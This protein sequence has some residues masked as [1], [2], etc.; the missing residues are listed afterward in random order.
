MLGAPGQGAYAAAN[1]YL[2]ALAVV[3]QRQGLP[4]T[5]IAWGL[6]ERESLAAGHTDEAGIARTRRSGLGALTDEQGLALFDAALAGPQPILA[7]VRVERAAMRAQAVAGGLAAPF[8]GLVP[9]GA[10]MAGAGKGALARRL[11][12]APPPVRGRLVEDFVRTEVAAILGHSSAEEIG[13]TDAFKDLGFDSLAAVELR[14]RLNLATGL[15]L[16]PTVVFD[17]PDAAALAGKILAEV[18]GLAPARRAPVQVRSSEEPIAI[19]GMACRYPGGI[20]SPAGLWRLLEAGEESIAAMPGD[21][22]WDLDAIYAGD[23]E[24]PESA[25]E[26]VGGFLADAADFDPGFFGISPREAILIDPQQR[27]ALESSWEALEDAGIDP[28]GLRGSTAGVFAGVMHHDYGVAVNDESGTASGAASGRISYALGL[29]GPA[30]TVD[31]ACSSSLVAVHLAAGALRSGECSLALAGGSTVL[32]RPSVFTY[33]IRQQGLAQDGRCKSFSEGADGV[34]ISEGVGMLVLE[35]LSD[36][37]AN[38]HRVLATIRGS[39]V[40]QDGASN[41]LS[42]PNGPSQERVILQALAN[43]GLKPADVDLVEAH[44]TGTPLGDPIEAGAIL[45]TYG[46]ERE[47]PLRLGSLKSNIGHTQAAAGVGGVIKAVLAM[48]EGLMPKTLHLDRA[49]SNVDWERGKV[50]LLGEARE[51]EPN[52]HPRRAGV[53]SFGISGTNAHLILEEA[54]TVGRDPGPGA[55]AKDEEGEAVPLQG[56]LPFVLSAKGEG[57]LAAQARRLAAH[58]RENSGLEQADLAFSLI[59]TRAQLDRRGVVVA[60][61]R[62]ALL[63]GLDALAR[64]ERPAT[65]ALAKAR[66][67]ARLAYLFS[68]QGSQRPGMGREL[69]ETYPAYA[70]AFDAVCAEVDPHLGRSLEALVFSEPG[71]EEAE[72]LDHTTYAQPAL[73]ATEVALYRLLESRGL[74]PDLLAGHSVGEIAAAHV[75]GVVSLAG[76]AELVAARGALMGGLP[77][78]GAMVAIE[79]TEAEALESIAGEERQLSLAAVNSPRSCVISGAEEAVE[80]V[81]SH[82]REQGRKTK[83]LSVSHAF[84]SP[85]MEP[86]LEQFAEVAKGLDLGAPRIPVVSC[87]TGEQLTPEQATDPS[88]WTAHVREPVRF[89]AAVETLAAEGAAPY[90]ELGPDPVLCAMASE[91]LGEEDDTPCVPTLRGGRAEPETLIGALAT[92]HVAGARVDWE[93]FFAGSAAGAV[94]LPTYSFQRERFWL[95]H[96]GRAS[97]PA[98][99]G[100]DALDHP[101]LAAAMEDTEGE[102]VA[103]SGRLSLAEHP[104]LAAHAAMGTALLPG[105]A[106]LELA[107]FAGEQVG[108]PTVEGLTLQAPLVLAEEGAVRLRVSVSGP[109]QQGRREVS[110]HSRP[111]TAGAQWI[112]NAAGTLSAD[113]RALPDALPEWPPQGAEAIEV[114]ALRAR[115]TEAGL[116]YGPAFLGLSAAWQRGEEVYAE[117]GLPEPAAVF[118]GFGVHPATLDAVL[119][120]SAVGAGEELQLPFAW[121]GVSLRGGRSPEL[122]ARLLLGEKEVSGEFFDSTGTPLGTV[123]ALRVRPVDPKQLRNLADSPLYGLAWERPAPPPAPVP[124]AEV[125][126]VPDAGEGPA[127]VHALTAAVL[128]KLQSHLAETEQDSRLAILA[129]GALATSE[130]E[131]PDVAQAAVAGLLR[132]AAAEHPG[133][134]CL[135]DTDGTDASA[136]AIEQALG[137]DPREVEIALRGGE[138][139]VPRLARAKEESAEPT[140]LDSDR[141]VLITGGTGG[142]GARIAE[143]LVQGHGAR[144]LLLVSRSG[145]EAPG[146]LDLRARLAEQG[147]AVTIAACDVSDRSQLE[148]LL[149]GIPGEHPLGAIVHGAAVLDD[150]LLESLDRERIERVFGPKA[151]AAWHLHELSAGLE[152][153]HFVCLSSI[154]GLLGSPAQAN[155]AAANGFLDAL[156]ARRRAQG[157]PA[158]S[159]AWG[160]WLQEEGMVAR[161]SEADRARMRRGGIAA[162]SEQQGLAL[163]DRVLAGSRALGIAARF[164]RVVL[165]AQAAAGGLPAKLERLAGARQDAGGVSAGA[166]ARRLREAPE[167]KRAQLAEDFVRAEVAAILGHSS[168][169]AVARDEVFKDLGFDSLA[170]I[171]L[172]NRL[173]AATDRRLAASVVFDYPTVAALAAHLLGEAEDDEPAV[174]AP[175]PT[176][177]AAQI[178]EAS[179]EELLEFIDAQVGPD[180]G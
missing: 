81:A 168:P 11:R 4:A 174:A 180:R 173:S 29:E 78:G 93:A 104:W 89:A 23:P 20:S 160:L 28:H 156:A 91:C 83:R 151:D 177:L 18:T 164:D 154:A 122:R 155:Y 76:A 111:E 21:R 113:S 2:D 102:G 37:E 95:A 144:N 75:G 64:G 9:A 171:E 166:L 6:W 167:A 16:P 5:S 13:L 96:K 135:I 32:A 116:E 30:M 176:Q 97:D 69:Y 141:T 132:S 110:V 147:A 142:I 134:F 179:D 131:A 46:Q 68:G 63:S 178:E 25:Y 74:T 94:P 80:R 121:S 123:G 170:A 36:A 133:R 149:A 34:G 60:S 1:R 137:A 70:E 163:F 62:E 19:V 40:N 14:N 145:E 130:E 31:T 42:A 169:A 24:R 125:W 53:S 7:A 146:A 15:Q 103:F 107:L 153:T 152:L 162:L 48:R 159:V 59:T 115:L 8:R 106:F 112:R 161:L 58:L 41:G 79:A 43:A 101:F 120:A 50:E 90:L 124:R 71:S 128:E 109:D 84:H 33:F 55:S 140:E 127:G 45:A 49:S 87:L 98:S 26:R 3:R 38:N 100:Q 65:L 119:Q 66:A 85:L 139:L 172:R 54:P 10:A 73:F 99:L 61:E 117:A 51:W 118:E 114:D 143:H 86:M 108:T 138:L 47:E 17:F 88:F 136:A 129:E 12:E 44:G 27:L 175:R 157:L 158:S 56:P 165:R 77:E 150:G 126:P 57:A 148:G 105:T 35:R 52:G 67:R 22:G 92:A 82:W 39:A 72:L